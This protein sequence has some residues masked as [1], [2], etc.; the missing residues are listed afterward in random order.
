M[1]ALSHLES[2]LTRI[3]SIAASLSAAAGIGW[4]VWHVVHRSPPPLLDAHVTPV[5]D[6]FQPGVSLEE[7]FDLDRTLADQSTS[8]YSTEQL[9][10]RYVY[11]RVRVTVD[12]YR[13]HQ[14]WL[15]WLLSGDRGDRIGRTLDELIQPLDVQ[16]MHDSDIVSTHLLLP[17]RPSMRVRAQLFR[18]NGG[19]LQQFS[20][21]YVTPIFKGPT[22]KQSRSC[23]E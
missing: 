10:C 13:G 17:A 6:G 15:R 21:P 23:P 1:R 11:A 2:S 18:M 5:P 19:Q 16:R 20:E 9:R 12:G 14:V 4:T 22:T 7:Y 3:G 8:P